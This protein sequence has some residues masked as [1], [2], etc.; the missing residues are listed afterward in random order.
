MWKKLES[1]YE[2]KSDTSIHMLLQ[3][4]YNY[5]KESSDVVTHIVKIENLAHRLQILVRGNQLNPTKAL[6]QILF[7]GSPL[8]KQE[9]EPKKGQKTLLLLPISINTRKISKKAT[10]NQAYVIIATNQGIGSRNVETEK[11]Q[12][13][14]TKEGKKRHSLEPCLQNII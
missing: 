4:W 2:Q 8:R 1:V 11:Q 10:L 14:N 5:Q 13:K 7:Q 12:T 3:Q 6:S 9:W